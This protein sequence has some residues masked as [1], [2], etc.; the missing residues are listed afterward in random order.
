M[1]TQDDAK[2]WLPLMMLYEGGQ[3]H[4]GFDVLKFFSVVGTLTEKLLTWCRTVVR[5]CG[6]SV[7]YAWQQA[8]RI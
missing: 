8:C 4:E 1:L 5:S 6:L 3:V 7:R 2:P